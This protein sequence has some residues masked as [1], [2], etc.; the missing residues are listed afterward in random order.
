MQS[1]EEQE[2]QALTRWLPAAVWHPLHAWHTWHTCGTQPLQHMLHTK[3]KL[4]PFLAKKCNQ[5]RQSHRCPFVF[6]GHVFVRT[7][8]VDPPQIFIGPLW[9]HNGQL[10]EDDSCGIQFTGWPDGYVAN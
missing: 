4:Q 7:P 6:E 3:T 10:T 1:L 9:G 5:K 2:E 8:C